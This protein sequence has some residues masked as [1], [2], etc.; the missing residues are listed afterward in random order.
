MLQEIEIISINKNINKNE[1]YLSINKNRF[2]LIHEIF[3]DLLERIQLNKNYDGT[4]GYIVINNKDY[5]YTY[6]NENII[7]KPI[8]DSEHINKYTYEDI[9]KNVII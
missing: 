5:I 2:P 4:F 1:I 9:F 3:N 7:A 6:H 8:Y